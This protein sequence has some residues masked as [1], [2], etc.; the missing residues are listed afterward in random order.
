MPSLIRKEK[1]TCENCG[2]QTTRNNTVRHKK[3]CPAGTLYCTQCPSFSTLF[4]DDLN[5]HIAKQHSVAGRLNTYKCKLCDA[6]FPGFYVLRQH[7]NTQHGTQIGFGASNIDVEDIVGDVDDQSLREE[8]QSCRHSLVDSEIQKGSYSVFNFVVNNLTAQVI[9][10]KLDRVLDKLKCVAKRNL[11]LGFILKKIE[12]MKFRYFYAHENNSL[13][14]QSKLV[15]NK[16]NMA[17]LKQILKKTD[18]I[19]SCAKERSNS[20]WRFFKLTNLTIFAALLRDIPMGCKDAFLPE[21]L[22]R[23]PSINCLTCEQNTK[24]TYKDNFCLFRALAPHLH[25]TER[26]Q[27]ETSKLFNLFLVNSTNPAPSKFQGVCMDDIPS[28]EDIVGIIIFIYDIDFID[29]A[30]VVELPRRSIKKYEKNVL[31]I[32]YKSHICYVD[33]INALFKAF[34]CSNCDIYFPKTG[35]MERHLVRCSERVKH[36]YPRNV[37]QLR[38]TLF[39][40]LDSFYVQSTDDQQLFNN[41]AV[42]VFESICIPEETFKNT[43]MTTWIGKHVPISV[44]ISSNLIAKPIFLC[45]SNPRDLVESFI[46]AVE[47]LATQSKAQMKLKLLEIETAIKSKLTRNLESLN[48]RRYRNQRVFEFEDPCFEDDNEEKDASTQFCKCR[49]IS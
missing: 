38:E 18:V 28:V 48:E 9:E 35:N 49:K 32:R 13:L 21:S 8:F 26:L 1:I 31:L 36:I 20:K 33:N 41:L 39:D 14:E 22:L 29:G 46:D 4:Q 16:D 3:R 12:D 34:R 24:K 40:K 6:E 15:S 23:N 5:Y 37:Y 7:R 47:G 11:A 42:L 17:K 44:P 30:M 10:E 45:N 27:E 43:E 25:R 19:E 2:T